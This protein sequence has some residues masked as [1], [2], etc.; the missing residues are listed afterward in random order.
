MPLPPTQ[1]TGLLSEARALWTL[2]WPI[3]L[4]QVGFMFMGVVDTIFAGP[5]GAHAL[6]SLAIG[7]IG[8]FALFVIGAGTMR[9]LDAWVSQA[10]GA[11][12]LDDCARGLAQSHWLAVILTP[13]LAVLMLA[14]PS[15]LDLL[16]YEP[17]LARTAEEYLRPL[18]WGLP[19]AL[20]FAAYRSFLSAV[21]ITVPIV[22]AAVVSNGANWVLDWLLIDGKLGAPALGVI[23]IAWST[24]AC[25]FVMFAILALTLILHPALRRFPS[26]L[27][28][29]DPALLLHLAAIGLPVGLAVF[30]EVASFGGVGVLMGLKGA[31]PLAAHQVA[32]NVTALL[33]MVPLGLSSGAAVR[34]GQALGAGDPAAVSRAGNTALL[35][36]VGYA[37][38]SAGTLLLFREPIARLY[39]VT[40]DVLGLAVTFL[41]VAAVYQLADSLQVMANGVLRGLGDTRLP[42]VFTIVGYLLIG[43]PVGWY[44]AFHA[45]DDP[46]WLWHGLTVGLSIVAVLALLRFRWQVGHLRRTQAGAP[47]RQ[48]PPIA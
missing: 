41:G 30:A 10:W 47:G 4:A 17:V 22:I 43:M 34:C 3:V 39:R 13:P 11:G 7:N 27:R 6:G 44:G 26:V 12:R 5:L 8:F 24:A 35:T 45:T 15:G 32:L 31:V 19:A 23:G 21:N 16:G 37:A 46:V 48:R 20:L 1:T 38:L 25:R 29:P 2:A 33:F 40:D 42:L 28:P 9:S 14:I 36:A 18:V